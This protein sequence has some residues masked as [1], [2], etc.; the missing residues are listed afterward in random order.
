MSALPQLVSV[1]VPPPADVAP[2]PQPAR[3]EVLWQFSF[4]VNV[5]PRVVQ[6]AILSDSDVLL[7]SVSNAIIVGFNIKATPASDRAAA[8]L[9]VE[10]RGVV[11]I[12]IKAVDGAKPA[13][14]AV[15][16]TKPTPSDP[17][18]ASGSIESLSH[19]QRHLFT[20]QLAHL[21]GAGMTLDESLAGKPI[22]TS[23]TKPYGCSVK[24][25]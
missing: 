14:E 13:A 5:P 4:P 1:R 25:K 9:Q 20:E 17:Q 3:G 22:T 21:L 11:P 23:T 6:P 18:T 19:A 7:A 10:R 2:P 16:K 8:I 24:Y 12:S 15:K